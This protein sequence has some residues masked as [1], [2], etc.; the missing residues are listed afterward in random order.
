MAAVSLVAAVSQVVPASL[1]LSAPVSLGLEVGFGFGT[2]KL[3]KPL[4]DVT[5]LRLYGGQWDIPKFDNDIS[6]EVFSGHSNSPNQ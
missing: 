1:L 3:L 5:Q 2:Q 4:D 6:Y